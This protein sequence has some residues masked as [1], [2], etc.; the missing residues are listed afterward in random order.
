MSVAQAYKH[1][2]PSCI[3][4]PGHVKPW[5]WTILSHRITTQR[6][7]LDGACRGFAVAA[8]HWLKLGYVFP[9]DQDLHIK[10]ILSSAQSEGHYVEL[11]SK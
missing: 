10:F 4:N 8:S 1:T 6:D 11:S 7:R 9:K 5:T 3:P 2:T